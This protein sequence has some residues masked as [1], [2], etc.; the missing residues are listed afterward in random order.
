MSSQINIDGLSKGLAWVNVQLLLKL[1]PHQ[2]FIILSLNVGGRDFAPSQPLSLFLK[3]VAERHCDVLLLLLC[4]LMMMMTTV[5]CGIY[6]H[7]IS[8]TA[9]LS[10]GNV[11]HHCSI[12]IL[13]NCSNLFKGPDML[14]SYKY[15]PLGLECVAIW[16]D[17]AAWQPFSNRRIQQWNKYDNCKCSVKSYT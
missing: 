6:F 11:S 15:V 5:M 14:W 17:S 13:H 4:I 2:Y 16:W 10:F 1:L 3:L 9:T 8:W 12:I 7:S